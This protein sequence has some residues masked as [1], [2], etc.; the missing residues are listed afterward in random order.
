[1]RISKYDPAA[2]GR[3]AWNAGKQVGAK[4]ALKVKQI[5][6]IRFF[7]DR[8]GRICD[9]A[10]FDLA[11]DSKLRGCDLVKM[12]IGSLVSGP[13]KRARSMVIQ[14]KTG[15]PVQ[16][17]FTADTRASLL[18][19]LERRSGSIDDYAFPSRVDHEGH[20]STRQYARL[21]DEWVAAIGLRAEEYGT[22]SLRR[23]KAAL[24]YKATGNLRAIQ[25]LL[26]QTKIENTVR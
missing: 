19:G 18:A 2:K 23:T 14:Q 15:R 7:L 12:K 3:P 1:M 9:R 11:I 5:W 16:F 8:E 6:P 24:I 13:A 22:H 21:V 17:E 20:L 26:R 10:L 25:I 4:R